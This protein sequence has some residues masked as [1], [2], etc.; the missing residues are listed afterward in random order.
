MCRVACMFMM[1]KHS[2][3]PLKYLWSTK[4]CL[5]IANVTSDVY[6]NQYIDNK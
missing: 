3:A 5:S 4:L 6:I 1:A 2:Q